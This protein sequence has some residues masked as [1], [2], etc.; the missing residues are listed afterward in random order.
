[1]RT[2]S[3]ALPG[4]GDAVKVT[5]SL[6]P[7]LRARVVAVVAGVATCSAVACVVVST[8]TPSYP[9]ATPPTPATA[10]PPAPAPGEPLVEDVDELAACAGPLDTVSRDLVRGRTPEGEYFL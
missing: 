1:M 10:S 9:R 3:R 7:T 6:P 8:V 5:A 4:H 2:S